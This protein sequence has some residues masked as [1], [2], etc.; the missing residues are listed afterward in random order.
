MATN[1]DAEVIENSKRELGRME[2]IL[3][4]YKTINALVYDIL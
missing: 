3:E 4:N 1:E 2:A